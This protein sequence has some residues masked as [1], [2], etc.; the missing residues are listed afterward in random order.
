MGDQISAEWSHWLKDNL[1]RGC[2]H[3]SILEAMLAGGLD[4]LA[5][6]KA[7]VLTLEPESGKGKKITMRASS[8]IPFVQTRL[9]P[10]NC[11]DLGDAKVRVL[12][13]LKRPDLAV[14]ENLLHPE[15]CDELVAMSR[16]KLKHSTAVDKKTGKAEVIAERT[17]YGAFF[18]R[19]ENPLVQ[20]L[21]E[22][23]ARLMNWPIENGEGLQ[24]LRYL[25]GGEY[26]PH[27]DYFPP[28]DQ[29][30][31]GHLSQAG[32]RV[33]TLIMYLNDVEAGGSTGFPDVGLTVTPRKGNAVYFAYTGPAGEVDPMSLH[34]GDPVEAGEKWIA[35]KWLRERKYGS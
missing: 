26:R 21:E 17:S 33:A 32:Q 28:A 8:A 16:D 7:L 15:E 19:G 4:P 30:S 25:P 22:R 20:R 1:S 31:A 35:T 2:T 34:S 12:T 29:G 23:L 6:A 10:G 27:F 11:L 9:T 3:K 14:F 13:R 18:N 24:I 5:A